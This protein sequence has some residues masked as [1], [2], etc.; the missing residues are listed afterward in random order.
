MFSK[1]YLSL[2]FSLKDSELLS[3]TLNKLKTT[4]NNLKNKNLTKIINDFKSN[5]HLF[6]NYNLDFTKNNF[7]KE[8]L[9]Y[10]EEKY[11]NLLSSG[12]FQKY[13]PENFCKDYSKNCFENLSMYFN[14]ILIKHKLESKLPFK[15]NYNDPKKNDFNLINET[16]LILG[17]SLAAT[18]IFFIFTKKLFRRKIK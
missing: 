9:K 7:E 4:N 16:P 10:F 3:S 8:E 13:M 1:Y 14:N 5:R 17:I 11:N 12:F 6:D 2:Y 18:Y 15:V